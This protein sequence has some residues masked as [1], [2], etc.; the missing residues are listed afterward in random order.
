MQARRRREVVVART[1]QQVGLQAE[2]RDQHAARAQQP[3]QVGEHLAFGARFD[4]DHHV[5]GQ[6]HEVE[7]SAAHSVQVEWSAAGAVQGGEIGQLPVQ[8]GL[9]P[10]RRQH[11]GIGVDSGHRHPSTG[12]FDRHPAGAAPGVEHGAAAVLG[13]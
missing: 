7:W 9:G 10:R 3:R 12:Q 11:V 6:Q 13:Q 1:G 8:R 4:E 5:A 2:P